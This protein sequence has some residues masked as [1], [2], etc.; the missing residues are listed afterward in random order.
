MLGFDPL[1]RRERSGVSRGC[2]IKSWVLRAKHYHLLL[3]RTANGDSVDRMT[4][5]TNRTAS[6]RPAKHACSLAQRQPI[7]NTVINSHIRTQH[8]IPHDQITISMTPTTF[9]SSIH[10]CIPVPPTT[11]YNCGRRRMKQTNQPE[12][13][14]QQIISH[15]ESCNGS[16]LLTYLFSNLNYAR[17]N[18]DY[19]A[20][21]PI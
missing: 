13:K 18:R 9:E 15:L 20:Y 1:H 14:Q 7:H 6:R 3:R 21:A 16:P 11:F 12:F 4:T 10:V 8:L 19:G 5:K 17:T 2:S